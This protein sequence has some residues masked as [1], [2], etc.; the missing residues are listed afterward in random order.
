MSRLWAA[1]AGLLGLLTGCGLGDVDIVL[2]GTVTYDAYTSGPIRLMVAESETEDCG[3]FSCSTQTP[4]DSVATADLGQPGA[5]SI[6][7]TVQ[8]SD[9]PSAVEL[10]A[11][12]LGTSTE[13]WN[14]EAGAALALTAQSH[15]NLELI[16][17]PGYCPMRE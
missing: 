9:S 3:L 8:D 11:Y 17:E 4:G 14:C 12:A 6:R 15:R 2:S 13:V 7:A 5:F 1:S 16:L 10:L